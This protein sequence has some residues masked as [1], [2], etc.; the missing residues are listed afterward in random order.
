MTDEAEIVVGRQAVVGKKRCAFANGRIIYAL[1]YRR[2]FVHFG[3]AGGI[4]PSPAGMRIG[5]ADEAFG[6]IVR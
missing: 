4:D 6:W 3:S 5:L 1:E 2:A